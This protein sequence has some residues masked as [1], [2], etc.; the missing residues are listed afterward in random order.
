MQNFQKKETRNTGSGMFLF[1]EDFYFDR[2]S[3]IRSFLG[4]W[5][6]G[7]GVWSNS[8]E[9]VFQGNSEHISLELI[10]DGKFLLQQNNQNFE[11]KRGSLIWIDTAKDQKLKGVPGGKKWCL[12]FKVSDFTRMIRQKIFGDKTVLQLPV[13]EDA[14][15]LF[16][17]VYHAAESNDPEFEQQVFRLLKTFYKSGNN[18]IYPEPLNRVLNHLHRTADLW[19][20][21]KELSEIAGVSIS[22]LNRIF[23]Q[24]LGCSIGEYCQNQRMELAC[25][26]LAIPGVSI[27]EAADKCGFASSAFF[28]RT[29]KKIKHCTPGDYISGH[30]K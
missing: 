17:A 7:S 16:Q 3:P 22:T 1:R 14:E 9:A 8:Y 5:G 4:C 29:F 26:L 2:S 11:L 27:K 15:P 13:P 25:R 12:F 10:T 23:H 30:R 24:Y 18:T 28:C 20:S 19:C 6:I 21:R